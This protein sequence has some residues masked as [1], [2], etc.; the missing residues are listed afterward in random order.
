M[1]SKSRAEYEIITHNAANFHV[2][3]VNLLYRTPHAHK[4]FEIG[5]VLDGEVDIITSEERLHLVKSDLFLFNPYQTHELQSTE[6]ALIL[7]V[8]I[9]P[10]YFEIYYPKINYIHFLDVLICSKDDP[11]A[12]GLRS[13]LLDI[14]REFYK[15]EAL[16]EFRCANLINLLFY[17]LLR[18]TAYIFYS[19]QEQKTVRAKGKRVR[20]IMHY[21]DAHYTEKI[22]L[23]DIADNL[24]LDLYYLSH[25][26]KE[27]FG[28]T[29]QH[30][31]NKLRCEHARHL[32]L[33]TDY[34]LL[35]ISINSGFSD[36]KYFNK[37]FKELY[38]CLP[39]QYRKNFN[40]LDLHKQQQSM[41]STQEFLS[42]ES[43]I[44]ILKI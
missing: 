8:Q 4:D 35:D 3:L 11:A 9:P 25:F 36:P 41:L 39:K 26:F 42:D 23:S 12:E 22:L 33:V 37:G 13:C 24:D 15:K 6:P 31:V 16:F 7:S 20:Q 14:A 19:E 44:L 38:G 30:Y 21:I 27:N 10:A 1:R 28:T 32:L 34:S 18:N 29:F 5:L 17:D 43:S 2:F 40:Q